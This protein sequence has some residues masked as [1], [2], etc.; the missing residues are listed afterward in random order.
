MPDISLNAVANLGYADCR[1]L[2]PVYCG[3]TLSSVSEVIGVKENSNRQAGVVYLRSRGA[4]QRGETVIEYVRWVMVRK[5]NL[6]ASAPEAHVPKLPEAVAV[7][8]L[9][10]ACPRIDRTAFD[11]ALSGSSRRFEDYAAGEESTTS[12]GSPSRRLST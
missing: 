10:A 11:V 3:D 8:A 4:N 1:F 5:R 2:K 9:G 6:D 12:K 7:D